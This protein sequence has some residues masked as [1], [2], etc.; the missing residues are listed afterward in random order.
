CAGVG[1]TGCSLAMIWSFGC[2]NRSKYS[3]C[4]QSVTAAANRAISARLI[5]VVWTAG[6][7]PDY[8]TKTERPF[9]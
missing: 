8:V 7:S 2:Q 9:S 1:E 5:V 6:S 4:S 3:R